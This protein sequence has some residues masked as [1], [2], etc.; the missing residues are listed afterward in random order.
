MQDNSLQD[1]L[2]IEDLPNLTQVH[3]SFNAL[4]DTLNNVAGTESLTGAQVYMEGILIANGKMTQVERVAGTEGFFSKVGAGAKKTLDYIIDI[5]KRIWGFFF[6]KAAPEQAKKIRA[7][8]KEVKEDLK[9]AEKLKTGLMRVAKASE[10]SGDEGSSATE[11]AKVVEELQNA[12]ALPELVALA[13]KVA[14]LSKKNRK[15]LTKRLGD[16]IEALKD[17]VKAAGDIEEEAKKSGH[18]GYVSFAST[19]K[20]SGT[21]AETL[22][23]QLEAIRDLDNISEAEKVLG[24]LDAAV[25]AIDN[26]IAAVAKTES[27]VQSQIDAVKKIVEGGEKKEG[28]DAQLA[29]LRLM[30]ASASRY[31]GAL[32][33]SLENIKSTTPAVGRI[34]GV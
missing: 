4:S 23:K 28:D 5:F 34:F 33:R 30:M 15:A 17:E 24:E 18:P 31:S 27:S 26:S 7:D 11:V 19:V 13:K 9:N 6:K 2:A 12:K 3:V 32:K 20:G 16:L 29:S 14:N 25:T 21:A 1:D 10:G 22:M 8:I